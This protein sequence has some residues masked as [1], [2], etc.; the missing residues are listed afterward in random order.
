METRK[1]IKEK[2]LL[3]SAEREH[4]RFYACIYWG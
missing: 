4:L 3:A 2:K 1:I